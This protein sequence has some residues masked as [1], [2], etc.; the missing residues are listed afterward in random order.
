MTGQAQMKKGAAAG[1]CIFRFDLGKKA[2]GKNP[3]TLDSKPATADYKEF[4]K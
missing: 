2:E 4:I 3:F 1:Y